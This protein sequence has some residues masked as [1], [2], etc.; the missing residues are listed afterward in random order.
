MRNKVIILSLSLIMVLCSSFSVF[1][2]TIREVDFAEP[3]TSDTQGYLAIMNEAGECNVFYWS[4]LPY[5]WSNAENRGGYPSMNLSLYDDKILFSAL[6][7]SSARVTLTRIYNS[8][9]QVVCMS[10]SFSSLVQY[11]YTGMSDIKYYCY[12]GNVGIV[13][14]NISSSSNFLSIVW[15]DSKSY[16]EDFDRLVSKLNSIDS[17]LDNLYD[18]LGYTNDFL[19]EYLDDIESEIDHVEETL[20]AI[21]NNTDEVEGLLRDIEDEIDY[22][23]ETLNAIENNTD[24]VEALLQDIEN[25]LDYVEERLGQ[26][27]GLIEDIINADVSQSTDSLDDSSIDDLEDN[28]KDVISD[29]SEDLDDLGFNFG[30]SFDTVWDMISR[31]WQSNSKVFTIVIMCLTVG[32]I[33]LIL[34]R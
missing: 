34:N 33:K 2:S 27:K 29:K 30:N 12:S 1:A 7:N 17:S 15:G 5:S 13:D 4:I 11:S 32:L 16:Q 18:R 24:D 14:D 19:N 23:E 3:S 28:E 26:I 9:S 8:S 22:V 20:N 31:A 10:S 6:S 21:E 25:E